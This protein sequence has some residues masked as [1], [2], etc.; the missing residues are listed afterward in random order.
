MSGTYREETSFEVATGPRAL[1]ELRRAAR[2]GLP[3]WEVMFVIAAVGVLG[4]IAFGRWHDLMGFCTSGAV[5][6]DDV[7]GTQPRT[8]STAV[9]SVRSSGVRT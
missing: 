2:P 6:F 8:T 3:G 7:S 9:S 1:A 5:L 4:V